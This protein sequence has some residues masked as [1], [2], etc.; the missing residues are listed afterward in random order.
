M[1]APT[2]PFLEQLECHDSPLGLQGTIVVVEDSPPSLAATVAAEIDPVSDAESLGKSL[3]SVTATVQ[4][5]PASDSDKEDN[6]N[7][8][9]ITMQERALCT[10][11]IWYNY[12]LSMPLPWVPP[13]S[14]LGTFRSTQNHAQLRSVTSVS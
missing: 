8:A 5:D 12:M 10:P 14:T 7:D 2:L 4:I 13:F 11:R 6:N 9:S 3:T 1:T